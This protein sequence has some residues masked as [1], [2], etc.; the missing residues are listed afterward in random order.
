MRSNLKPWPKGVSGN[1]KGRP[2]GSLGVATRIRK[3]IEAEQKISINGRVTIG[4]PLDVVIG[5]ITQKAVNGDIR[6]AQWLVKN[7][8]DREI[9]ESTE[10]SNYDNLS[11]EELDLLIDD[12]FKDHIGSKGKA[13]AISALSSARNA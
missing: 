13:T 5:V 1:P 9:Y 11:D 12:L 6:S 10:V 3:F 8:Y 4:V 7:A 2:K